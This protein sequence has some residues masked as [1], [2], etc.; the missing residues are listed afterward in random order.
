[1]E[2]NKK[3]GKETKKDKYILFAFLGFFGVIFIVDAVFVSTA[4][5]THRGV[6]TEQAYEKGLNYNETL[7]EANEQPN[8]KDKVS[9]DDNNTLRWVL[10][11]ETGE[12]IIKA[13]VNAKIIRPIQEGHDFDVIL[14]NKGNGIYEAVLEL[15]FK[16]LW[17]VKLS[18]KWDNQTYKTT[19]QMIQK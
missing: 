11:N 2:E 10:L 15:P 19:Y 9:F 3:P 13:Q 8:L 4:L 1:M 6:I 18:S 12:P 7:K 16:G 17:E 5:K 14:S